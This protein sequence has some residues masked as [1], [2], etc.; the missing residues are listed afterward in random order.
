MWGI[1]EAFQ[2]KGPQTEYASMEPG[3][4]SSKYHRNSKK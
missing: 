2:R 3:K 4:I 1:L